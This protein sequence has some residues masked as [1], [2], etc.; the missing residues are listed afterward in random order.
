MSLLTISK[1]GPATRGYSR[2]TTIVGFAKKRPKLSGPPFTKIFASGSKTAIRKVWRGSSA[3]G[4]PRPRCWTASQT[5]RRHLLDR[6]NVQMVGFA[7]R[8]SHRAALMM[9]R[10]RFSE[11]AYW[12]CTTPFSPHPLDRFV[13]RDKDVPKIAGGGTELESMF[14][15]LHLRLER[16][17]ELQTRSSGSTARSSGFQSVSLQE[18]PDTHG[19]IEAF[20]A[21][22]KATKGF[23]GAIK[24]NNHYA[25]EAYNKAAKAFGDAS[26]AYQE[27]VDRLLLVQQ[28]DPNCRPDERHDGNRQMLC[29]KGSMRR[30]RTSKLTSRATRH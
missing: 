4:S 13:K 2:T 15:I 3:S 29:E 12:N 19:L 11:I 8:Q 10:L 6:L 17:Y 25:R 26:A 22:W 14:K 30:S 24:A 16:F 28:R 7:N 23:E 1:R 27:A 21:V 5:V 18:L 20:D 9:A